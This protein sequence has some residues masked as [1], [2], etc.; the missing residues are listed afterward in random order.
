MEK[1]A[2]QRNHWV[3]EF[4]WTSLQQ[5]QK[6]N[7]G[8][9]KQNFQGVSNYSSKEQMLLL[10]FAH[11]GLEQM[12]MVRDW[13]S[14]LIMLHKILDAVVQQYSQWDIF[15]C[16]LQSETCQCH[17]SLR[18]SAGWCWS[19]THEPDRWEPPASC[20]THT[21]KQKSQ[22]WPVSKKDLLLVWKPNTVIF[23]RADLRCFF[24][25]LLWCTA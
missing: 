25:L 4:T 5:C 21:K 20:S 23:K 7:R 1:C 13:V 9:Q 22:Y 11:C 19:R 17:V 12:L 6:V 2:Q 24:F 18:S 10:C 16:K 15:S 3:F 8:H 14:A